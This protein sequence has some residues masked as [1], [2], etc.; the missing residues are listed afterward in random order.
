MALDRLQLLQ[1]MLKKEPSDCFLNYAVAI[2]Y[3]KTDKSKAIAIFEDLLSRQPDYLP[4]YYQLGKLYEE[5]QDFEKAKELYHKGIQ[6]AHKQNN[7]K[8]HGELNEA[9]LMLE[10]E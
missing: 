7:L 10:D 8:T 2:E 3:I 1:D 4:V 6:L 5:K 9:L